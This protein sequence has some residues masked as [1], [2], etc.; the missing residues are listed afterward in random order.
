MCQ[1]SEG[2]KHYFNG[3]IKSPCTFF[4]KNIPVSRKHHI[5]FN[6]LV[7]EICSVS[8]QTTIKSEPH[9]L[10][11]K[12]NQFWKPYNIHCTSALTPVGGLSNGLSAVQKREAWSHIQKNGYYIFPVVI[13]VSTLCDRQLSY[14]YIVAVM[15]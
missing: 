12:S 1:R 10:H 14:M 2:A 9:W 11:K 7:F 5:I 8:T 15:I 3:H 6:F 13:V 4:N